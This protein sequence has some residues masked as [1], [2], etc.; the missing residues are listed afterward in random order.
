MYIYIYIYIYLRV[1]V[2][3]LT[4]RSPEGAR[5]ELFFPFCRRGWIEG[6]L[7]LSPASTASINGQ[8]DVIITWQYALARLVTLKVD[9][10]HWRDSNSS[11][12]STV[13]KVIGN[14]LQAK[15]FKM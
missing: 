1:G 2:C 11:V 7:A 3:G 12:T 5:L 4:K 8:L 13:G 6:C 9:W 15:L 10:S 14:R